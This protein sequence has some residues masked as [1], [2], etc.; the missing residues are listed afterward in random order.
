MRTAWE[1]QNEM[2]LYAEEFA[3]RADT[4]IIGSNQQALP[5]PSNLRVSLFE[6]SLIR[7][8]KSASL[9]RATVSLQIS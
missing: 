8:Q 7:Q 2:E 5:T 3:L 9:L 1:A 4:L 6:V